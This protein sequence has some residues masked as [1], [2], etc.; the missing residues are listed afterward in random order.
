MDHLQFKGSKLIFNS[1]G[2]IMPFVNY[3]DIDTFNYLIDRI[4]EHFEHIVFLIPF[5]EKKYF[6]IDEYYFIDLND[7]EKILDSISKHYENIIFPFLSK[8][9]NGQISV[10]SILHVLSE[11]PGLKLSEIASKIGK[12]SPVVKVYLTRMMDSNLIIAQNKKYYIPSNKF[13]EIL[14]KK[15]N[16]IVDFVFEEKEN[17]EEENYEKKN[18]FDYLN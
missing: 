11:Y 18:D 10:F 16:K 8:M 2:D 4:I 6:S 3:Y 9:S 12:K 5:K 1:T 7:E 17:R 15:R 14:S 13:T